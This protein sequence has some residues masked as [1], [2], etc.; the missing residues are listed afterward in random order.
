[1]SRCQWKDLP[2]GDDDK[3]SEVSKIDFD[4]KSINDVISF[5]EIDDWDG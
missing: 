1:M 5:M 3:L 4:G 2:W